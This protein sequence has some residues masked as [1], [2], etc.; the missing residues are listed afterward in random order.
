MKISF[1]TLGCPEWSW[2]EILAAA[3]DLGYDGVEVRGIGSNIH[4]P[5]AKP[6]NKQ[7]LDN[8]IK[9]LDRMGLTIPCLTSS[10][11][12]FVK[13]TDDYIKEAYEYIDLASKLKTPYIRVL[14]DRNPEPS[15]DIDDDYVEKM[16]IRLANYCEGKNVTILIETNGVYSDSLRLANLIKKVSNK[17][18][19]A[20]WDIHHPYRFKNESVETTYNNLKGYIK[21]VHLKDSVVSNDKINYKMLGEGDVPVKDAINLLMKEGYSGYLSLEWVKRWYMDLEEPGI[22]FSHFIN[23]IKYMISGLQ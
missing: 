17:N 12:L 9:K 22:V 14:G 4:V 6:F 23:E 8:S 5:H 19:A 11:Y 16:L 2:S 21:H 15:S 13:E 1:S 20:L 3:K 10:C 7:N 18:V